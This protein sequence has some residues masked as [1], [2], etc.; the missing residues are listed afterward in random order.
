MRAGGRPPSQERTQAGPSGWRHGTRA[1][2]HRNFKRLWLGALVSNSGTW[3]EN[4]A[5]PYLLLELTGAASWVGIGAF[6]ALFPATFISPIAGNLADRF[7]RRTILIVCQA[8]KALAAAL[9]WYAWVAGLRDPVAIVAITTLGGVVNGFNIPVWQSFVPTLVPLE[10]LP[11]AISLNSLQ[12]NVARAVGP[13]AAGA[14]L[15]TL[16]PSWAFGLNA[17]SFGA[18]LLAIITIRNPARTQ[19]RESRPIVRGFIEALQYIKRQPGIG[20]AILA[21][22]VIAFFGY[23]VVAFTTVFAK[24]VYGVGPTELGILSS[25]LGVGAIMGAPI[26]SGMFGD[27]SRALIT[28]MAFPFYGAAITIFGLSTTM[29]QGLFGLFFAGLGFL[30]LVA[31]SNTTVQA[32]VA[33]RI[34][35]RVMAVRVMSFTASYPLGALIQTRLSDQ[36]GPRTVVTG[37][38]LCIVAFGTYLFFRPGLASSLDDPADESLPT[39]A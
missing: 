34:R 29:W 12:F 13:A 32:I 6:A 17:I 5:V 33:D 19:Q 30:T 1:L 8:A 38:G 20:L 18:I 16:G 36:F 24:Q 37:A 27:L 9:L 21:A 22:C 3:L 2:R 7:D 26:V 25:V 4:L 10:D 28:R 39:A 23:P 11:S 15:A 14:L 35:G 31:T